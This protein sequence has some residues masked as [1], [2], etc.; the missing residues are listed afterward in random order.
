MN[1][2]NVPN[3]EGEATKK[4]LIHKNNLSSLGI[5]LAWT[6]ASLH[7]WELAKLSFLKAMRSMT[8]KRECPRPDL[9]L[10]RLSE[11]AKKNLIANL[12]KIQNDGT[13]EVD[14]TKSAPV[15]SELLQLQSIEGLPSN[16]DCVTAEL[17]KSVP[18]L[19]IAIIVVGTRGDVQPFLAVARRLQACLKQT[20]FF[21]GA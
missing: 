17:N 6:I 2:G 13:V 7:L 20:L 21:L 10:D 19:K 4:Y 16:I 18:K 14:L 9:K 8:D 1:Y 3:W 5:V 12:V 11:L 15:A